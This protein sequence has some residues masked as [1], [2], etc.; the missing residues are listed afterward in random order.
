MNENIAQ[1]LSKLSL[2][3]F[4]SDGIN[5]NMFNDH[6]R[7]KFYNSIFKKEIKNKQ[8][9]DIG[10]G[11]GILSMIALKNGAKHI[12][13]FEKDIGRYELGKEIIRKTGVE[14]RIT[15]INET[16]NHNSFIDDRI[17]FS[18]IID[19]K[20]WGE[21]LHSC[22]P[23]IPGTTFLPSEYG[24]DIVSIDLPKNLLLSKD[25]LV[26]PGIK[27]PHKYLSTVKSLVDTS[28]HEDWLKY[29]KENINYFLIH[30][31]LDSAFSKKAKI[32]GGYVVKTF[33][34]IPTEDI[35]FSV[36]VTKNSLLI[37]RIY[38]SHKS[39]KLYL[40]ETFC[41]NPTPCSPIPVCKKSK[42]IFTHNITTGCLTH[43]LGN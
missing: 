9:I 33:D 31:H 27:L 6:A 1:L 30:P 24:L 34:K 42:V 36:D 2:D 5:L 40:H 23:R 8:C 22:L 20:I 18:E 28:N 4:F 26:S 14:D 43:I 32:V 38:I 17:V 41:W 25:P 16:F 29:I 13:A 37:P 12:L 3:W 35:T 7:N 11:T 15:L 39:D 19:E 10:F 21:G